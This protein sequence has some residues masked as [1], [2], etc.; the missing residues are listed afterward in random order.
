MNLKG[1]RDFS[2]KLNICELMQLTWW[3]LLWIFYA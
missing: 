1:T 3:R 2:N